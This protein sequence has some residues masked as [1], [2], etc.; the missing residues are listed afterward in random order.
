M[1][2]NLYDCQHCSGSG[3]CKN[4]VNE[5]SCYAC[6]KRNELPF[7]RRG[8]QQGLLCGSCGGIGQAEPLT[9]RMNKRIAPVLAIMLVLLLLSMIFFFAFTKNE[10]FSEILAFSSAVIGSVVGFY[11]SRRAGEHHN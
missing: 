6:A 1:K 3:T 9:E 8:N 5:A 2:I 7:W 11:F 4:G 10:Y